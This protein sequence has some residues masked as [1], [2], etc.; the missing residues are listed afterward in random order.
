MRTPQ[1]ASAEWGGSEPSGPT[2]PSRGARAASV[3]MDDNL[4]AS[5]A[6]VALNMALQ[7]RRPALHSLIQIAACSMPVKITSESSLSTALPP[8]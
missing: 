7:V 5:L 6:V 4:R 3:A 2:S 1:K 8:A